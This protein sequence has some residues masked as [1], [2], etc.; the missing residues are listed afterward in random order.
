MTL[1]GMGTTG[2]P[3][4]EPYEG[5]Y[6]G[7]LCATQLGA[8]W[9]WLYDASYD[10]ATACLRRA[11]A[12]EAGWR[13]PFLVSVFTDRRSGSG[14]YA[15]TMRDPRP[16]WLAWRRKYHLDEIKPITPEPAEEA[17]DA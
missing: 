12:L 2:A 17:G 1:S 5:E 7:A 6:C 15:Y 3:L 10:E 11:E 14:W 8:R 13:L 4:P 9:V 16:L